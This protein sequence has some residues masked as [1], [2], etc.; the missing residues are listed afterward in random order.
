M[1]ANSYLARQELRSMWGS[2]RQDH[3]PGQEIEG[4]TT[5]AVQLPTH[6]LGKDSFTSPS[7]SPLF[8]YHVDILND[9]VVVEIRFTETFGKPGM[10]SHF[11]ATRFVQPVPRLGKLYRSRIYLSRS[12]R[13]RGVT[14]VGPNHFVVDRNF[15]AKGSWRYS[16]LP[17]VF[18]FYEDACGKRI[19]NTTRI[20][21][22]P[23]KTRTKAELASI[24][25]EQENWPHVIKRRG[26][27]RHYGFGMMA[28]TRAADK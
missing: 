2:I 14:R 15:K 21:L 8:L 27:P 10:E 7:R 28:G 24:D 20:L 1:I 6:Y 17:G 13:N 3:M 23:Y 12:E 16:V 19:R 18:N 26:L 25:Y 9:L 5:A 4:Q 11:V 22:G